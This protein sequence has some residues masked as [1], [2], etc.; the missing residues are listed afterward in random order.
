MIRESDRIKSKLIALNLR[1]AELRTEVERTQI[2]IAQLESQRDDAR[3]A[4][5]FG[6]ALE[7]R[8]Q[9]EP[10][11]QAARLELDSQPCHT[12]AICNHPVTRLWASKLH[13][14]ANMGL[15]DFDRFGEA[16]AAC[17]QLAS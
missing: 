1:L 17:K 11:L 10:Q 2:R 13:D 8:S 16:Y 3:L 7:G 4:A 6:E 14:L 12:D 15:S 5:M 9:L